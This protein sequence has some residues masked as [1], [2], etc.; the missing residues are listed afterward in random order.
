M[1]MYAQTDIHVDG[2]VIH[3]GDEVTKKSVS[4]HF[5]ALV[6]AGALADAHPSVADNPEALEALRSQSEQL[7]LTKQRLAEAMALLA[8]HGVEVTEQDLV[9]AAEPVEFDVDTNPDAP[10]E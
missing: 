3:W 10:D 7:E 1:T 9:P 6:A 4:E 5:D 8:E 2:K